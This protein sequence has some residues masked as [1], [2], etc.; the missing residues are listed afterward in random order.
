MKKILLST[1][2]ALL[3]TS[4]AFS[5]NTIE[6]YNNNLQ[7]V[8]DDTIT[9]QH[10]IDLTS[11]YNDFEH[12]D[13]VKVVNNTS[14]T[15]DIRVRRYER[16]IID[17]T[18]DYFCWN[19]CFDAQYSGSLPV[20]DVP[21]IVT[22]L[23]NDTAGGVQGYTVYFVPYYRDAISGERIGNN[24]PGVAVYEYEFYAGESRSS[25]FV[26]W[27]FSD[28]TS[29]DENKINPVT[30]KLYPNPAIDQTTLRFEKAIESE[31]TQLAVFDLMGKKVMET[32]LNIGQKEYFLNLSE[33]NKGIYFVSVISEGVVSKTSKLVV[34]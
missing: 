25:L 3:I 23:P 2:F 10:G 6:I 1:V 13:F 9:F 34:H 16:Q 15:V 19:S 28:I 18:M 31:R 14:D 27:V 20:W 12:K 24:R 8:V 26:K 7:S 11:P 30:F 29:I 17:S 4:I 5:Q 32:N 21:D 33:F 22:V